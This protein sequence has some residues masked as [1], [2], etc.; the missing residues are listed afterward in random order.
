V[1]FSVRTQQPNARR[2][3]NA[4]RSTLQKLAPFR[5]PALALLVLLAAPARAAGQTVIRGGVVHTM[6]P[7]GTIRDG[8]VIIQDG[9]I[10]VVG[11]AAEVAIPEGAP[12]LTAEV[13][14]PGLI[15]AHCVVGLSGI[16]NQP[17]DSDQIERS[18]P[19]QP[20]LR[21]LDA[22]NPQERL[23]EWVRSFGVTTIHT[24]H[25]WGEL[26]S[27]QTIIVKTAGRTVE[28]ALLRAPG[29]VAATLSP[30]A[31]KSDG[32]SPGTRGKMMALLRAE[33]IRAREYLHK[34]AQDDPNQKPERNL[35]Y[36]VLGRVLTGEVP[37][38][39]TANRAQDIVSALRLA[40]EFGLKV[41]LDSAAEAYLLVNEIRTADVP[42]IVHPTMFRAWGETENLSYETAAVLK[43]AGIPIALQSGYESYVPKTRVVLFEAALAAANGLSFEDALASI[44]I[45]AARIL[46]IAER[47]G[48]LEVGKD[49]DAALYDGDPFEYTTHCTGVVINGRPVSR[50]RR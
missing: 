45:D 6:G 9:R 22:Y 18:G 20:E 23:V 17:H 41:W 19:I 32:K 35:R 21:A 5:G 42:V 15:D 1:L 16:Y 8:V 48:S 27:G 49:G 24:G 26:I 3:R 43:R 36:E 25:A 40:R 37:L 13:V 44:T 14:T 12:V 38:M 47:V 7:A 31:Q 4:A 10:S 2:R 30:W 29:A 28:E 34:Q 46:G 50:A 39:I 33:L 11:T